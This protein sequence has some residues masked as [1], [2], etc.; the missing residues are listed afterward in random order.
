M[1]NTVDT[2]AVTGGP[3]YVTLTQD[4][5]QS[6]VNQAAAAKMPPPLPGAADPVPAAQYDNWTA[7]ELLHHLC[8]R[9]KWYTER[10]ERSAHAAADA[11]FPAPED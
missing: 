7:N 5:F 6:L 9:T 8:A 10:E 1:T 2:S 11:H 3:Q 4:Q